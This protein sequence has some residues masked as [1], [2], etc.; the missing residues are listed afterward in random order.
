MLYYKINGTL[1]G[2]S[3]GSA[4]G[5]PVS[6]LSREEIK[7][8]LGACGVI[9]YLPY[10]NHPPGT[11]SPDCDLSLSLMEL[12][13]DKG[14]GTPDEIAEAFKG[15]IVA[16]MREMVKEGKVPKRSNLEAAEKLEDGFS[17]LESGGYLSDSGE[18]TRAIPIGVYYFDREEDLVRV[19]IR[20]SAITHKS[21]ISIA[22]SV[23]LALAISLALRDYTPY[24]L[25]EE[26]VSMFY[27]ISGLKGGSLGNVFSLIDRDEDGFDKEVGEDA[28]PEAVL[29]RTFYS[30][31]KF[32]K[33]FEKAVLSA[34]NMSGPSEVQGALT[35]AIVGSCKTSKSIP[36]KWIDRL[37]CKDKVD[38]ISK[39][40]YRILMRR[41]VEEGS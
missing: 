3:I 11:V 32:G 22:A 19:S 8:K 17:W 29:L 37:E 36:K 20:C 38:R 16:W 2:M 23:S 15:R 39:E 5:F 41:Q 1:L 40:M 24:E 4:L 12:L 10:L 27:H 14:D 6:R 34:V 25:V 7:K 18:L 13:L 31:L 21:D 26:A 28:S 35:G 30:F 33:S 9:D